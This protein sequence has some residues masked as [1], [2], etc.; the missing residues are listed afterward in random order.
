MRAYQEDAA[1]GR[2]RWADATAEGL[3]ACEWGGR[4]CTWVDRVWGGEGSVK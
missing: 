3:W 1:D 2:D 4:L